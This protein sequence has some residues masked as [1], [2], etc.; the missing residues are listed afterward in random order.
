MLVKGWVFNLSKVQ[1]LWRSTKVHFVDTTELAT[2]QKNFVC[3]CWKNVKLKFSYVHK[4]AATDSF[5]SLTNQHSVLVGFNSFDRHENF[6]LQIWINFNRSLKI[7]TAFVEMFFI[8]CK[9]LLNLL[10]LI[11]LPCRINAQFF[12]RPEYYPQNGN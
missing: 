12:F 8:S 11:Y 1:S 4:N 9:T 5:W 2:K 7:K 10:L 3:F 6:R